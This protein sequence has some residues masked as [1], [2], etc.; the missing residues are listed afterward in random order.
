MVTN[1]S[2]MDVFVKI[3]GKVHAIEAGSTKTLESIRVKNRQH[4]I[5]FIISQSLYSKNMNKSICYIIVLFIYSNFF[6]P[7]QQAKYQVVLLPTNFLR[8]RFRALRCRL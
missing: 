3:N 6:R 7:K 1:L 5:K 2:S 8:L 4:Q